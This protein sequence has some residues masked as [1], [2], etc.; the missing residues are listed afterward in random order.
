[1]IINIF[2]PPAKKKGWFDKAPK[3]HTQLAIKAAKA[4]NMLIN[5]MDSYDEDII[6]AMHFNSHTMS[7]EMGDKFPVLTDR[8]YFDKLV[9][10][11]YPKQYSLIVQ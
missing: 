4:N 3:Q 10:K 1:M 5:M 6:I 11:I 7:S 2:N 8:E 9:S